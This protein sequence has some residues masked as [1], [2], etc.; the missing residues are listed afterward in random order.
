MYL[1][2]STPLTPTEVL[3]KLRLVT[4]AALATLAGQAFAAPINTP[5]SAAEAAAAT[6]TLY[7]SG[8]SAAKA[9]ISGLV[10]QNCNTGSFVTFSDNSGNYNA[11]ACRV[12]AP[13]GPGVTNPNDWG[14]PENTVVVVNKRDDQGSG[15]GVFP[16]AYNT[17]IPFLNLSAVDTVNAGKYLANLSHTPD[18]GISD[19]EPNLFNASANRPAQFK[20]SAPVSDSNFASLTLTQPDGSFPIA[21]VIP[22]FSQVFGVAVTQKLYTALQ[23][24]Q[25]TSGIPSLSRDYLANLLSQNVASI[26]WQT[27]GVANETA[28][29]NICF[30][31]QGSGTRVAGNVFFGQFPG[32]TNAGFSPLDKTASSGATTP[33]DAAGSVYIAEPGSGGGVVSCLQTVNGLTTGYGI[34][35]LG[36]GTAEA[37]G[38][39][40]VAIDG[41]APSREL[42]KTGK[43][44]FW[45]ES[46]IQANKSSSASLAA[47]TWMLSFIAKAQQSTNLAQLSAAAQNGVFALPLSQANW[48][49]GNPNVNDDCANYAG[50]YAGVSNANHATPS[51][52]DKFCGRF[53]REDSVGANNRLLPT[54]VK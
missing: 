47:K 46:T 21:N 23:T 16:V 33:S 32:N 44:G 8:S 49:S 12:T 38:F 30:R 50:D 43:Y 24:A 35:L 5:V 15:F 41:V 51:N 53:N 6:D 37:T 34:G 25:G 11:Y 26:G 28:G 10:S 13:P 17:A 4:L 14:L 29:V 36:F 1:H 45:V 42:A 48:V 39:K 54:F 19:V 9:I 20:L 7:F 52:G 40:Y 27:L 22:V 31:D 18:L 2:I 3:M